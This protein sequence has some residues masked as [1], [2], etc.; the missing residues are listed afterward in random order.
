MLVVGGVQGSIARAGGIIRDFARN[1]IQGFQRQIGTATSL[2]A[3]IW[4]LRDGL[5]LITD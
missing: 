1:W 3:E 2:A 5:K 4:A